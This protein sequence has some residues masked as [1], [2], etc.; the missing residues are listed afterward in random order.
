M[1]PADKAEFDEWWRTHGS[2]IC[3]L[4]LHPDSETKAALKVS[5]FEA[6]KAAR[7]ETT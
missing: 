3:A 2:R 6:F 5:A 4:L 7:K 1:T